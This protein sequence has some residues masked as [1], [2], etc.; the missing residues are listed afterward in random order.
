MLADLARELAERSGGKAVPQAKIHLTLA[1]LGDVDEERLEDA[2][3]APAGLEAAGFDMVLDQVGSFSG[4]RVGWAGCRQPARGLA[5]LQSALV[6]RLAKRGFVPDDRP[7]APHVTLARKIARPIARAAMPEIR[8]RARELALVR[9]EL[10]KG[11][12][13]TLADWKLG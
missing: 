12:Y 13:S 8:W 6:R 4:A 11:S 1:F 7:Y 9:S 10:G 3:L 2:M 5:D